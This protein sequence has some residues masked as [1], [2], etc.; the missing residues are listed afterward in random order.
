[1]V[2]DDSSLLDSI[3]STDKSTFK[4]NGKV[5]RHNCVYYAVENPH[6]IMTQE[7]NVPGISVWCG[8]WSGGLIGPF[9]FHNTVTAHSYLEMLHKEIVPAIE[10]QMNTAETFFMHDGAP[11][12]YAKSVRQFLDETF[13]NQWIGWRGAIG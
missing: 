5:N 4:L 3:I 12:H 11:T 8:I 7:M 13:P 2:A 10:D 9:F 1:M 6:M